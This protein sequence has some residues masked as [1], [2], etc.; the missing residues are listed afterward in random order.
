MALLDRFNSEVLSFFERVKEEMLRP[1]F[2]D[3]ASAEESK[4]VQN[5]NR[6]DEN[7]RGRADP[8]V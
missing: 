4:D 2:G 1:G 8:S 7:A 6:E 3:S 5:L